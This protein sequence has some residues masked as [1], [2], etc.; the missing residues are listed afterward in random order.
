MKKILFLIIILSTFFIGCNKNGNRATNTSDDYSIFLKEIS[1]YN[2]QK[3][4]INDYYNIYKENENII[5]CLNVI[6]YPNFLLPSS[7]THKAI[8]NGTLTFVNTNYIL[9]DSYVPKNLVEV[10]DVDY[11]ERKNQTMKLEKET[12]EAYKML[13]K[14]A[15]NKGYELTIFS[16]Y[17][18][19][20]YQSDLYKYSTDK[21]FVAKPGASEHQTGLAIDIGKRNSGLTGH[22][23]Q[24][25]ESFYLMN[26]A[27]KFGFILRYPKNGDDITGYPYES[28][29]YRYV[30]K[31]V[32]EIIHKKNITLEEYFY[33]YVLL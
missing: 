14:D 3:E 23:D 5:Y 13:E 18:S 28:W 9:S 17:R 2:Y 19:Y 29:H 25:K 7:Y 12:F 22:F 10:T 30:G 31:D 21:S 4:K 6:N 26:N 15:K 20:E 27:Y 33:N 11:I 24:T 8:I 16:A 32:A 1:K